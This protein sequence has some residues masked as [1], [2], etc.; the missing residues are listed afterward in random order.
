MQRE[1]IAMPFEKVEIPDYEYE[2]G[3]VKFIH[4]EEHFHQEWGTLTIGCCLSG[5]GHMTIVIRSKDEGSSHLHVI[6][7]N[8]N[9][10]EA[11]RWVKNYFAE[12]DHKYIVGNTLK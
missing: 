7:E 3:L 4:E 5:F 1:E 10:F 2:T 6:S 8:A 9:V 11:R 12:L